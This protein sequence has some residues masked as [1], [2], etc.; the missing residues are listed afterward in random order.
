M[1]ALDELLTIISNFSQDQLDKFL[2]DNLTQS[3]LRVEEE[4]SP[5][6]LADPLCG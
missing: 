2:S 5:Y 4:D 6:P 1:T 3:I